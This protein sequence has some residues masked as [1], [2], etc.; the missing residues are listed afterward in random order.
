MTDP[1][2][3]RALAQLRELPRATAPPG[4]LDH[5]SDRIAWPRMLAAACVLL[6]LNLGAVAWH[7]SAE[8]APTDIVLLTDYE[9]YG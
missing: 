6:A 1:E 9:I 5:V 7:A 4:L 8:E 3:D 2:F